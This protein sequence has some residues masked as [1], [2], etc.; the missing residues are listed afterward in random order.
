LYP[1][2]F[3]EGVVPLICGRFDRGVRYVYWYRIVL[4]ATGGFGLGNS[5]E[6]LNFAKDN[7]AACENIYHANKTLLYEPLRTRQKSEGPWVRTFWDIFQNW[8]RQSRHLYVQ[9][10]SEYP[11]INFHIRWEAE[12]NQRFS[13]FLDQG[14][15]HWWSRRLAWDHYIKSPLIRLQ[16]YNVLLTAILKLREGSGDGNE[17]DALAHLIEDIKHLILVCGPALSESSKKV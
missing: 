16:R 11:L 10:A 15:E 3:W 6:S 7:F 13:R 14:L 8:I 9:N 1:W 12:R 17:N 5:S 4:D 2:H